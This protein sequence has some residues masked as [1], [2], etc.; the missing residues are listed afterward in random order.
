ML[1]FD[2][3]PAAQVESCASCGDEHETVTGSVLRDDHAYAVYFAEWHSRRSEAY[4]DVIFGSFEGPDYADH[5]TFGCRVGQVPSQAAPACSLVAAALN[6]PDRPI[7][8]HK[9]DRDGALDH[10]RL[11]EFWAVVDW[12]ILNDPVLHEHVFHLPAKEP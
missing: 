8:G 2:G 3:D 6:R 4:I 9:L 12:L 11:G 10:P 5:V 1:S 7:L